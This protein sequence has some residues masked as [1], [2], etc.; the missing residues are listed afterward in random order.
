GAT[1][2]ASNVI[3]TTP[4]SGQHPFDILARETSASYCGGASPCNTDFGIQQQAFAACDGQ[5]P[6]NTCTDPSDSGPIVLVEIG[7]ASTLQ[8]TVGSFHSGTNP[9]LTIRLWIQGL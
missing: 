2:W 5:N 3:S 4:L 1:A 9:T 7:N 8:T 6:A